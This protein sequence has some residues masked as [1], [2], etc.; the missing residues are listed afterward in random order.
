MVKLTVVVLAVALAGTA[1]AER[2][3]NLRVDGSSEAAFAESLAVFKEK[4]SPARQYVFGKALEDIWVQGTQKAEADQSEYTASDY[5][6]QIDGLGYEEVV[7]LPDPT[8]AT[9]KTRLREGIRRS[10][11]T[12]A[13]AAYTREPPPR[14]ERPV[15]RN[16]NVSIRGMDANRHAQGMQQAI[17]ERQA[18]EGARVRRD[19]P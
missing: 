12:V 2:W 7:T 9:A 6:R 16:D 14:E 10:P 1:S 13:Q 19:P 18:V 5:Y 3:R 17:Q 15:F 11:G 4:L 8:G